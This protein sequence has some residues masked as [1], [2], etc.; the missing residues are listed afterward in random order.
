M[1][2]V[3]PGQRVQLGPAADIPASTIDLSEMHF[4]FRTA[5]QDVQSPN[6]CTI[7][8]F[9]LSEDTLRAITKDEYSRVILQAGYEGAGMGVIFDGTIKWFEIGR[10][11][12]TD[13]YLDILAAD[14]DLAYNFATVGVTIAGGQNNTPQARVNAILEKMA[15]KGVV[16]GSVMQYTGGVLPRGKVLFG[17]ARAMLAQETASQGATWNIDNGKINI[18]PLSSYLPGEAV[19]LSS[20][21]GLIGRPRQT[22][23]GVQAVSL[24]NP[25]L[26]V[27]GLVKIDNRSINQS[28][29]QDPSAAPVAFNQYT[30]IQNLATIAADGLYRLF[31]V[32]HE[33][34]TRGNA[35]HSHLTGL[36]LNPVTK[37]L[38]GYG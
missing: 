35:W 8:I 16:A 28:V 18:V 27:A 24:L 4:R 11:N 12:A 20:A 37:L 15:E 21:T 19:V 2:V 26:R 6:N 22:T 33:G 34:D 31:V 5:Q 38:K 32:E 36:A 30:G 13:T 14:G 1:L 17:M 9:N 25:R 7:R 23:D 29:Q 10:E 3:R